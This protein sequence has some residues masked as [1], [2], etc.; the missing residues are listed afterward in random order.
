[1]CEKVDTEI[2]NKL[3]SSKPPTTIHI[4]IKEQEKNKDTEYTLGRFSAS[5]N[6]ETTS[7][8]S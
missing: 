6:K 3:I 1:M 7:V 4:S 5:Y 2:I 8:A